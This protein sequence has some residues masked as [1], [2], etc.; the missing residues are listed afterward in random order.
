MA[1]RDNELYLYHLT[2]QKQTNFVHSCIGHFVDLDA[3]SNNGQSQLCVATETHLELYDTAE[4]ELKL[5]TRFQNLFTTITSMRSLDLPHAGST[6]NSS[7]CPTFLVLTSDSGNLSIVQITRHAGAFKLR[8]LVNQPL[9]RTTLRRASP[10]SYMEVDPNGRCIILSSVEQNKLCFLVDFARELRISSPLEIIRPHMI[11]LDMTACDVNFNNP[12][13]IALEMDSMA[14]SLSVHLIFYVLELGLNHIVKKA[15][16]SV[17]PSANFILSLPDLSKYNITTSLNDNNYDRDE[18]SLFN[19]FVVIGFENHILIKDMN[20]FYSLK[21]Q[22]PQ[23]AAASNLQKSVTIISGIV[24]KLKND[25]FVLLQSNYGDLFKLTITPDINDRNRPLVK[26]SYFD[27][28]QNSN[29]LHIFKSGYLFALS[30]MNN[31]FLFQFEKLGVENDLSKILTSKDPNKPLVFQPSTNLQN[32]SI[33]S[34]QLNLNPLGSSQ[35]SN[36]SPLS[37]VTQHHTNSKLLTLTSGVNY[38]NLISTN[39]PPNATK[40][41]LIPHPAATNNNNN[42]LFISFPKKT[43][44]L[45]I[46]NESME[47]LTPDEVARST[48]KLSQDTTIH[49]CL[50]SSHSIIQV[51]TTELRQIVPIDKT[52]FSNKLTWV[53]PAGIRII[54]ATSSKTQLIVSLSNYELVYFK[55]DSS[56]NSLIELTT[57]PELD[58]LPCKLAVEQ[59]SQH[60]DLLAIADDEGMIKIMSLRDQKEDFLTVISLQLANEKVSDMIMVRDPL[61]RLL[62]LHVGLVNGVY[63]RFHIQEIDGLFT[64][65]KRRFLGLKP[66]VLSY[67]NKISMSLNEEEEEEKEEEEEEDGNEKKWISCV[68]CHSASTWVSYTWNNMWNIRPL[69]GQNMLSCSKF[70]NADVQING[71]CSISNSGHLNIGQVSG[72]STWEKWFHVDEVSI[73]EQ[74]DKKEDDAGEESEEDDEDDEE[75]TLRIS[76][77]QPRTIL[78]FPNKPK[79][80]LFIENHTEV[81]QCRI[82]LKINDDCIKHANSDR[83]F[84][85][86]DNVHCISA[87]IIDFGKKVDH[88]VIS[89]KDN[90]LMTYQVLV[91]KDESSFDIELLHQTKTL[92]QIHS[93]LKFKNHLLAAIDSTIIL[94]GLGKKQLLRRSV[95]ET[96]VS[97]TKIVSMDQWNYERLA[98]GDIHESVT[99]FIWNPTGNVFIPMVDDSIKRHVTTLKFLDEATII[100]ADKFGNAWTLRCPSECENIISSHE[101]SELS[102]GTIK[103][104]L[105]LINLQQRLPNT[106]DCKFKF[107]VLNHLYVNDIIVNFHILDSISNSD[108]PG[109]IYMGLQ[110]TIGCFIPLLSK[111]NVMTMKKIEKIMSEAD[112]TFYMEYESRKK[113]N[114]MHS[115]DDEEEP[116]S[117]VLHRRG[118]IIDGTICEGSY[119][120]VGRDH[121]SYR[122]YYAPVRMVIDG[123]LCENFLRLSLNEQEFLAKDLK[124]IQINDI[125]QRINEVRTN[126]L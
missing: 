53:P 126:Y 113:N 85:L 40:L 101:A 95:T 56:S 41:W 28:I 78:S 82:S 116:A 51:C 8:T 100:G 118:D 33:L 46:D 66:V 16:Y 103:Y 54:C 115:E 36:D 57:H 69:N 79:H 23:R 110:G 6:A 108:R 109:C 62:N 44:I 83:S 49:T 17:N 29:Q 20:G 114:N 124:N 111:G 31:N 87:T 67:L 43:M 35:I 98:V 21:V 72:F 74:G 63:M 11:T 7:N 27:T 22:I 10:I 94:Y 30:E 1:A 105:N 55:I 60:S 32:L 73:E 77:F 45:Q 119:S 12:C 86:L 3:G 104:P 50:M 90:R 122:S 99:L 4:G 42:L 15:D 26:L 97:I 121:Q 24:Q 5:I 59:D 47:E 65:I 84:K 68:V 107:D 13:F 25:F 61:T 81:P 112:D 9:T 93:M 58:T 52:G 120:I 117:V 18:D 37:I 38:S 91:N 123:D 2:L 76:T 70:V 48:F 71:V 80:A 96:P 106:Y 92:S 75:E 14:A 125:I 34:Q 64:D 89:T 102:D 19:P 39:L 88:L